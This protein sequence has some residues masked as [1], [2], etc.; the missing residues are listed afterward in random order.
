MKALKAWLAWH[1]VWQHIAAPIWSRVPEKQR[2]RI[3][4]WL[5]HSRRRCWSDLVDDALCYP[6][7]DAC[8]IN[9]PSL[10]AGAVP[11]CATTCYVM[12]GEACGDHIGEHACSCYCGK[13]WFTAREGYDER[14][15]R[16]E[17]GAVTD[18]LVLWAVCLFTLAFVLVLGACEVWPR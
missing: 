17:A 5:N 10:R 11:D 6:E 12:G 14:I 18:A 13:F 16:F 7:D 4:G 2:W 15:A 1:S 9:V 3:V 8:D